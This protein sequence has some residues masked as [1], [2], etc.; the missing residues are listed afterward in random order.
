MAFRARISRSIALNPNGLQHERARNTPKSDA[1]LRF[2]Q[3]ITKYF[4]K[5]FRRFSGGRGDLLSTGKC[6]IID[7]SEENILG[8]VKI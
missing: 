3:L 5:Y 1:K 6:K 8:S 7:L 4:E 2:I